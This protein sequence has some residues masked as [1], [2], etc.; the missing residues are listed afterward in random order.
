[1]V[2]PPNELKI[3]KWY[4]NPQNKQ[5][6]SKTCGMVMSACQV[7]ISTCHKIIMIARLNMLQG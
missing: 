2:M 5:K 3:L 7:S 6:E 4:E 1:M